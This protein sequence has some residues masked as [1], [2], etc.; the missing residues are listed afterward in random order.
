MSFFVCVADPLF[1]SATISGI[2]VRTMLLFSTLGVVLIV[3]V[4]MNLQSKK[5][6]NNIK[7]IPN[8]TIIRPGTVL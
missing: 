3:L 8:S 2:E 5:R 1:R 6:R 4:F 7:S